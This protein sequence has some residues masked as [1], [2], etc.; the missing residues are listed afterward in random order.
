MQ[1]CHLLLGHPWQFDVDS[2]HF[3]RSNKYTFI[4]KEKKVVLVP[5][6]LE[7]IHSSD[8]ARMK[9]EESEKRKLCETSKNSK[10]ETPKPSSHIKPPE[11]TRSP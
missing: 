2:V 9:R 6:S 1:A 10:G 8:V 5:L 11:D 4:H 3:G 7:D